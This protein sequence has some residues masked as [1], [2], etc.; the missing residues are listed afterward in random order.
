MEEKNIKEEEGRKYKIFDGLLRLEVAGVAIFLLSSLFFLLAIKPEIYDFSN[1]LPSDSEAENIVQMCKQSINW[2]DCY[3]KQIAQFNYRADLKETL[4]VL[5]EIEKLDSKTRDCHLISHRIATSEVDKSPKEWIKIFDY[6]DQTTCNNGFVHGV[7]EGRS[8]YDSSLVLNEKTIPE[9]CSQIEERTSARVGKTREGADDACAHIIGHILLAQEDAKTEI[10]VE[11]CKKIPQDIMTGCFDGIF[12]ENI[13]RE[14]LEAH[15]LTGKLEFNKETSI[16]L[17]DNCRRFEGSAAR[18]CWRELAHIYTIIT[19]N[20][21]TE[22]YELCYQSEN[23]EYAKE[24][25]MHSVNLMILSDN[26]SDQDLG[27]TCKEYWAAESESKSCISR[28]L[29]PLLGSSVD[30]ID[31][32]IVFCQSV[33]QQHNEFCYTKIGQELKARTNQVKR[34]ELCQKVPEQYFKNCMSEK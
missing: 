12:M 3:G 8:K 9:I 28:S 20:N 29:T 7:L 25:Y 1:L 34:T 31:R 10:A 18:S 17:E 2:R 27:D 26:Y 30:F 6:V 32:A 14:N 19:G 11:I 13:T 33:P 4:E 24:C 21:P 16:E 23:P 5:K 15:G 22:V